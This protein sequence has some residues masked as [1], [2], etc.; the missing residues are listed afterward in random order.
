MDKEKDAIQT[1][2]G[3]RKKL[4]L[5]KKKQTWFWYLPFH[6]HL[7]AK[8]LSLENIEKKTEK[9]RELNKAR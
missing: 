3:K 5:R 7:I 8:T 2:L 6:L 4:V 1:L 9:E